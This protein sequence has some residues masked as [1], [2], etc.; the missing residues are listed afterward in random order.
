M[1]NEK[2]HNLIPARGGIFNDLALRI[3][4]IMRLI[5]D[6]RVESSVEAASNWVASI[7]ESSQT[8]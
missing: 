5:G 7:F 3:K 4:L 1:P 8:L 6:P 2:N